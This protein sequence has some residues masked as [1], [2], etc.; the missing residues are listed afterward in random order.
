MVRWRSGN[1]TVCKT[2]MRQFDSG[3]HLNKR[4]ILVGNE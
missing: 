1:A 3:T 2:V 4:N